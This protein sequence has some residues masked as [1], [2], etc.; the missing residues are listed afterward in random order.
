[1]NI[2]IGRGRTSGRTEAAGDATHERAFGPE[3]EHI[4]HIVPRPERHAL[5]A[6]PGWQTEMLEERPS[7]S[8]KWEGEAAAGRAEYDPKRVGEACRAALRNNSGRHGSDLRIEGSDEFGGQVEEREPKIA[9]DVH[10]REPWWRTQISQQMDHARIESTERQRRQ[11]IAT[12]LADN[13]QH[14]R[15]TEQA[16]YEMEDEQERLRRREFAKIVLVEEQHT[17]VRE[18]QLTESR[19]NAERARRRRWA[20]HAIRAGTG[21]AA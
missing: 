20:I 4:P 15:M 13:E 7:R 6:A 19:D 17:R 9:P 14:R 11:R 21:S 16:A 18:A 2:C 3:S 5:S 1:M 12:V 8:E 10:Q